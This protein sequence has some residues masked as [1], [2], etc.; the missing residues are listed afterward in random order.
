MDT[1]NA[2]HLIE[3]VETWTPQP[4]LGDMLIETTYG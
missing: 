3:R 1:S 4:T 2:E